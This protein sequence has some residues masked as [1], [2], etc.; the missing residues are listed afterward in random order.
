[1]DDLLNSF[2]KNTSFLYGLFSKFPRFYIIL[3]TSRTGLKNSFIN[4][5]GYKAIKKNGLFDADDYLK[6]NP[7]VKLSRMDPLLHYMYSG[8]K[9]GRM[10]CGNFDVKY[11]LSKHPDVKK[12]NMNPLIHYSLYGIGEERK[13]KKSFK[14]HQNKKNYK[15]APDLQDKT[16]FTLIQFTPAESQNPYYH[17][18]EKEFISQGVD[19]IYST[20][21]N[22]VE[23]IIK[24]KSECIFHLHQP[25]PFYHSLDGSEEDLI[26]NSR[27]FLDKLDRLKSLGAKLV[28]TMHNPVPHNRKFQKI[29]EAVNQELF[30]LS[31]HI[32]VLGN[33]PKINLCLDQNVKTPVSV[34]LHPSFKEVYP[35]KM[36]KIQA[37]KEFGLPLDAII[38][39]NI[40]R[41]KP[42]KGHEFIIE[43]FKKVT[44]HHSSD[45][46]L[47][48]IFAGYSDE[49]DYF[50]SIKE[51]CGSNVVIID[52]NLDESELIKLIS[53]LDYS[54]F[55]FKDIWGSSTVILSLSNQVPTI[56][57]DIG[58]MPDYVHHLEN[59]LLF[60]HGNL[61]SLIEAM[62][63]AV[64]IKYYSHMQYM[65]DVIL[66]ENNI[67]NTVDRFIH[68]YEQVLSI[69][70]P[71]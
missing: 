28:W 19:F 3:N 25:S 34:V 29:D 69:N 64:N 27:K 2:T 40:G 47:I 60:K 12:S 6:R 39:G 68:I 22:E 66:D 23:K 16:R 63:I 52:R 10:I 13:A 55:A 21:F 54:V 58:T 59:G 8:Y 61:D 33:Y 45:K 71:V 9:K 37:R 42:Y 7:D 20:D 46:K 50:D 65:C 38:F 70:Q 17:M 15:R 43:A 49:M 57:P 26:L 18:L 1:M 30:S 56:V 62:E 32:V 51:G 36:D 53:A 11:Y 44:Q 31:D 48:L 24:K 67:V 5:K 41:I 35:A 14:R 4:F